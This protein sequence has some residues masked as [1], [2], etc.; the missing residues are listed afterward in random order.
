MEWTLVAVGWN[1]CGRR[2]GCGGRC[3]G[4]G[5]GR[6]GSGFFRGGRG[7]RRCSG[8]GSDSG[9]RR[10][11]FAHIDDG[12]FH[13]TTE[14]RTAFFTG[15]FV[16]IPNIL[17]SGTFHFVAIGASDASDVI[18]MKFSLFAF[19]FHFSFSFS[20]FSFYTNVDDVAIARLRIGHGSAT[21]L[22]RVEKVL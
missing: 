11:G 2:G 8:S 16:K 6:N 13:P 5:R 20:F 15:L 17:P 22:G 21:S 10:V 9:T 4:G 7:S 18:G 1:G 12:A 3:C 14:K 19:H